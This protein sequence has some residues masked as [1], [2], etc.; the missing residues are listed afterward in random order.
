MEFCDC[1]TILLTREQ[2]HWLTNLQREL[3]VCDC[4]AIKLHTPNTIF[5]QDYRCVNHC[6][7]LCDLFDIINKNTFKVACE[8]CSKVFL[9]YSRAKY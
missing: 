6:E 9:Q 4:K 7:C 3:S 8:V 5:A 1:R 2:R